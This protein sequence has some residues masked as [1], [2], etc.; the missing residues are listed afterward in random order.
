MEV[1]SSKKEIKSSQTC[2]A[3]EKIKIEDLWVNGKV[4]EW[5]LF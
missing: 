1:V 3:G 2:L 4:S 5:R